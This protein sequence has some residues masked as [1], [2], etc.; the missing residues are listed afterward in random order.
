MTIGFVGAHAVVAADTHSRNDGLHPA[1]AVLVGC[2]SP[3]QCGSTEIIAKMVASEGA[4]RSDIAQLVA[5]V[6]AHFV[7]TPAR[8]SRLS[9]TTSACDGVAGIPLDV[10]VTARSSGC[11][12]ERRTLK[13]TAAAR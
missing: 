8:I 13:A 7:G 10:L 12:H 11:P 3:S 5:F 4:E 2:T 1:I 6:V 9:S